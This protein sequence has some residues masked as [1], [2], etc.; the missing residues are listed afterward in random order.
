MEYEFYELEQQMK[1][2]EGKGVVA[3]RNNQSY[4]LKTY[5]W[6]AMDL[7]TRDHRNRR[8][9]QCNDS[10]FCELAHL[11]IEEDQNDIKL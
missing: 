9:I 11:F 7:I 10:N 1:E 6:P 5:K 3:F 8:T 4:G 2:S